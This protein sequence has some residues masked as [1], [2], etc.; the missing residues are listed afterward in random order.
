MSGPTALDRLN[1]I[2]RRLGIGPSTTRHDYLYWQEPEDWAGTKYRFAYTPWKTYD[3]ET[4]KRGFF[5]LKYRIT[6]K[7]LKLV[8]K[9]RFG[10]RKIAKQRSREW[11]EKHYGR[12]T[13]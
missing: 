2:C 12:P 5:A 1:E 3:P 7:R 9:V 8:K 4:G 6:K 11:Y 10:R 13:P